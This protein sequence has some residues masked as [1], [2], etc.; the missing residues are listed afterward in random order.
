MWHWQ[1]HAASQN[2]QVPR[3]RMWNPWVQA[4]DRYRWPKKGKPLSTVSGWLMAGTL[5]AS[6]FA[7]PNVNEWIQGKD[8]SSP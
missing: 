8:L 3:Q 1:R 5:L 6:V 4:V 7:T 2:L